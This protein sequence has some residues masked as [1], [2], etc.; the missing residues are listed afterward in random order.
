MTGTTI[1]VCHPALIAE[2]VADVQVVHLEPDRKEGFFADVTDWILT[3]AKV[4]DGQEGGS[5]EAQ[6]KL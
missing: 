4:A 3:R 5:V 1:A 2:S 6:S